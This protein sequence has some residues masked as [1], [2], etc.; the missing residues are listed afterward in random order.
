MSGDD[1]A[2]TGARWREEDSTVFI[3]H[4]RA[5][6][7]ERERQHEIV[8]ELIAAAAPCLNA[9]ELCCGAGDLARL[10]LE[11]VPGVRLLA[12]DGSEKML[13]ATRA[14]CARY[15]DRLELRA[16]ELADASWRDLRPAPDAIYSSLAIHHLDA[17]Q[18]RR[19][20]ADLRAALHPGGIFVLADLMRPSSEAGWK[21]AAADWQRAVAARSHAL[22]GDDRAL[23]EF[24]A[25]RWNYFLW[26]ADKAID[27]PSSVA[28]HVRWLEAAGFEGIDLHW[29]LAG[30][31]ILSAR[32][33]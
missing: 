28:E 12:L 17:A 20:F 2:A 8:C 18:K 14:R 16:F 21:I 27:H 19:L 1:A 33:P 13:A 10:L 24:E 11:R 26:P 30:Q 29:M 6:T 4:G 25:L 31:A 15:A 22:Y 23:R 32:R 9:V 7:P 3:D 5:F